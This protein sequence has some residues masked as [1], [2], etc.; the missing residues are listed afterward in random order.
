MYW[1]E[2]RRRFERLVEALSGRA[3][4][5]AE[6]EMGAPLDPRLADSLVDVMAGEEQLGLET[7]CVN[8]LDYRVRLTGEEYAVITDLAR[9]WDL[10]LR[11]IGELNGLVT[12]D[13]A[14]ERS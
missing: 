5:Q 11:V 10:D 6:A 3:D 1:T 14:S 7:L 9:R 2:D 4:V 12:L 8:A 13:D